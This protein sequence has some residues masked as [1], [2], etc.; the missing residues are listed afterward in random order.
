MTKLSPIY[1]ALDSHQ[2]NRAIKL[3]SALPDN[4]VLG[5]ALL[6]HAYSKSGQ[7]HSALVV[8]NNILGGKFCEL[9]HEVEHSLEAVNERQQQHAGG[10]SQ[11]TAQPQPAA[12]SNKKGKKGKKKPAPKPSPTPVSVFPKNGSE[13]SDLVDQLNCPPTLPENWETLP[14]PDKDFRDAVSKRESRALQHILLVWDTTVKIHQL[15]FSASRLSFLL[16]Y[17]S[18]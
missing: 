15:M 8:L 12:S 16:N 2:Y 7:R 1:A 18:M 5:K 4:N 11:S 3:A 6:A 14:P 13:E 17:A 9:K 10:S